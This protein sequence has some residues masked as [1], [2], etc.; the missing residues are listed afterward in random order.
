MI[1]LLIDINHTQQLKHHYQIKNMKKIILTL[2]LALSTVAFSQKR[3]DPKFSHM[4]E[5][6]TGPWMMFG[7]ACFSTAGLVS[8]TVHK[9]GSTTQKSSIEYQQRLLPVISGVAVFSVGVV[10]TIKGK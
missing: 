5:V 7:G 8:Y 6:K 3:P 4:V 10:Y 2:A 9:G 1:L